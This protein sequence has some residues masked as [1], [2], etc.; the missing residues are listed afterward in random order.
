MAGKKKRNTGPRREPVVEYRSPSAELDIRLWAQEATQ[1]DTEPVQLPPSR[2]SV[3]IWDRAKADEAKEAAAMSRAALKT[4]LRVDRET[5]N[6]RAP[7][8]SVVLQRPTE[9]VIQ[10]P[11]QEP[12]VIPN[13]GG[14]TNTEFQRRKQAIQ[15]RDLVASR[16]SGRGTTILDQRDT[17]IIK[18]AFDEWKQPELRTTINPATGAPQNVKVEKPEISV[19]QL[20]FTYRLPDDRFVVLSPDAPFKELIAQIRE[21]T[22]GSEAEAR[23]V[24]KQGSE[25]DRT[26]ARQ[27]LREGKSGDRPLPGK[28]G[29]KGELLIPPAQKFSFLKRD[30][31]EVRAATFLDLTSMLEASGMLPAE[32]RERAGR[33]LQQQQITEPDIIAMG[34]E[35]Y[36]R[37]LN[38][39]AREAK[40]QKKR[41]GPVVAVAPI[42]REGGGVSPTDI[43]RQQMAIDVMRAQESERRGNPRPR[44]EGAAYSQRQYDLIDQVRMDAKRQGR[45]GRVQR[46]LGPAFQAETSPIP[47]ATFRLVRE[48]DIKHIIGRE[49]RFIDRIFNEAGVRI[50]VEDD[51]EV[52][53]ASQDQTSLNNIVRLLKNKFPISQLRVA[54]VRPGERQLPATVARD[55]STQAMTDLLNMRVVVKPTEETMV[56]RSGVRQ[57]V[58]TSTAEARYNPD[59]DRNKKKRGG[60]GESMDGL[61]LSLPQFSPYWLVAG[62]LAIVGLGVYTLYTMFQVEKPA[63]P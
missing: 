29:P 45:G 14:E 56:L 11:G 16:A 3:Q 63:E 27:G 49:G 2:E 19:D 23:R 35:D 21:A 47:V 53:L 57:N 42:R 36:Q 50:M 51:G 39:M 10:L 7:Q 34:P 13:E 15:R 9:T 8:R 4:M 1:F 32:A 43:R 44:R 26:L 24:L 60:G 5:L 25:L 20:P 18:R 41:E 55:D 12:L 37:L 52:T 62:S 28:L 46:R 58:P 48:D 61:G 22:G 6:V 17:G 59:Y 54:S 33:I 38:Q 40:E 30:R 31:N